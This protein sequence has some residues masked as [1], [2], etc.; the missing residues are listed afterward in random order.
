MP[1]SLGMGR[2]LLRV[3]VG[4]PLA[5]AQA[6]LCIFIMMEMVIDV[7]YNRH[8]VPFTWHSSQFPS[9]TDAFVAGLVHGSSTCRAVM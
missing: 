5:G 8:D 4:G 2:S 6:D 7:Y 3:S 1:R 9:S